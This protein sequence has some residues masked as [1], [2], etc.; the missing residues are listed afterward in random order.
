M[1]SL[2]HASHL[3]QP[4][5]LT[6]EQ[7]QP[8]GEGELTDSQRLRQALRT[9]EDLMYHILRRINYLSAKINDHIWM[10]RLP[11]GKSKG[12]GNN[13]LQLLYMIIKVI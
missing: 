11:I 9:Q 5:I 3:E 1:V 4:L 7:P 2:H 12:E 6:A 13:F 8:T 10:T